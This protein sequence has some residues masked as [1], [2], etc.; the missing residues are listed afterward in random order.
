MTVDLKNNDQLVRTP[1]LVAITLTPINEYDLHQVQSE[2]PKYS[3]E[4]AQAQWYHLF[5]DFILIG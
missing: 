1:G 4:I 2:Q 5:K 3:R